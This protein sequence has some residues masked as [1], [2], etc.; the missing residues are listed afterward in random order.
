[1][2]TA[3]M[4]VSYNYLTDQFKPDNSSVQDILR[5]ITDEL[6][7]G[8]FT[9][10]PWVEKFETSMAE[11][12]G[13]THCIGLNSGTDALMLGLKALGIGAGSTVLTIPNTFVA[14]VGA[15]VAVGATPLLVDLGDDYQIDPVKAAEIK[16]D[17]VIPVHLTG[18]AKPYPHSTNTI[19]DAAQAVGAA[20]G[21]KDVSS[22]PQLTAFSL[23]PLKNLNVWGDAG[24]VMTN[25]DG[26]DAEIRLLRNHGLADRDTVTVPGYNSRLDSLQAI[27]AWHGLKQIDWIIDQRISAANRYD[28]GLRGCPGVTVPV[29]DP[30]A[31]QVYHT[32]VLTVDRR[33]E[34]VQYMAQRGVQTKIHYPVPVH[35]Q[36]GY[37]FLGYEAGDFPVCEAQ[38]EHIMSLPIHQYLTDEQIDWVVESIRSF[39]EKP[40]Q[41]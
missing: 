12:Y 11:K 30:L 34:L 33:D 26:I 5:D 24:V 23:H 38:S 41:A 10:G 21:G 1:M 3:T 7:R 19:H 14:T 18:L 6:T 35:Q 20:Y 17:L 37:K 15:I 22:F 39:F 8:R 16:A 25:D 36:P 29:R 13:V 2:A 40:G 28:E 9:L 4:Q 32:Y 27:V 31:K